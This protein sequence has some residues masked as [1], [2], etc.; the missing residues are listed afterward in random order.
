MDRSILR[1]RYYETYYFCNIITNV[2]R[3]QFS[4][5]RNLNDFY[6]DDQYLQL[7][8]PYSRFSAF[9]SFIEFVVNSIIDEDTEKL[10]LNKRKRLLRDFASIP[11]AREDMQPTVLPIEEAFAFHNIS[12]TRF[13]EWLADKGKSFSEA[14]END[15]SDYLSELR[16]EG[17]T[18]ELVS[19]VV[20]ECFHILFSNRE[21]L[22]LFNDMIA[23]QVKDT[24]IS[25]IDL[26]FVGRFET[27]GRLKR[28]KTPKWA[29][30]AIY[31]RDKG[32]C[33]F[34]RTDLTRLVNTLTQENYDHIVPLSAGGLNDVTNLQ[35]TC[36]TCNKK[37]SDGEAL[38][39][40]IYHT[41]YP[42][43]EE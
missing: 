15:V 4:Y 23:G 30:H 6:G 43:Q 19:Q 34:C 33:V 24:V 25:E 20:R 11:A 9:H 13:T 31:H 36:E 1:A 32:L 8:N 39:S 3:D 17:S 29:E 22:L 26:E 37:K 12:H 35:L 41:W 5:L 16:D 21:T 2:L 10:D 18:D 40:D 38:T 14:D 28:A 27:N 7:T 42:E